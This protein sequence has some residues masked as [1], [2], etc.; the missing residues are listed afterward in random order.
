M[1]KNMEKEAEEHDTEAAD[2]KITAAATSPA[3][4]TTTTVWAAASLRLTSP[5]SRGAL[6]TLTRRMRRG[7]GRATC[8][9]GQRLAGPR[10]RA[11][12][13]CSKLVRSA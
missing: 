2:E 11:G 6:E 4:V 10:W 7:A 12:D 1:I 5:A 9:G 8:A 13:G 3:V